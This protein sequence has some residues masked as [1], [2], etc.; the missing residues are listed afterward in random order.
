MTHRLGFP[1]R[2]LTSRLRLAPAIIA[3]PPS[4]IVQIN[5]GLVASGTP[6]TVTLGV[7][8]T[9]RVVVFV[10]GNTTVTTP[11][12]WSL[13]DSQ[14]NQMG[15][16]LY[17][18]LGAGASS[19]NFTKAA[20]QLTWVALELRTG[21]RY[22]VSASANDPLG[23]VS[24]ATPALTPTAGQRIVLASLGSLSALAT[25]TVLTW[26]NNFVE[27]ADLCQ[28]TADNPMQGVAD[29]ADFIANGVTSYSTTA[30]F[31]DSSTGRSAIIVAYITTVPVPAPRPVALGQRITTQRSATW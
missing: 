1:A 23:A 14:V 11:G 17:D 3:A 7:A 2:A 24:Y 12:G 6:F 30:G 26:T 29:L 21:S 31:S 27:I 18:T 20:G 8:A 9:G 4:A 25:R 28:P 19:W 5:S 10:A 16:Y 22:D 13:R 15:H